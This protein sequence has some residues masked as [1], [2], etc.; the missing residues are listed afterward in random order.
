MNWKVTLDYKSGPSFGMVLPVDD[1]VPAADNKAAAIAEA[2]REAPGFGF[3][4]PVK[5]AT[6]VQVEA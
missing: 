3:D 1:S 5:K 2:K 4:Q 6:A